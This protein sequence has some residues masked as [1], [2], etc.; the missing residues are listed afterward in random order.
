MAESIS[1]FL[2]ALYWRIYSRRSSKTAHNSSGVRGVSWH[3]GNGKWAVRVS[4]GKGGTRT[5]GYFARLEDAA[6][7]RRQAVAEMYSTED[8]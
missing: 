6:E 2:R 4:N 8:D 1:A 3:K 7:A 5:V